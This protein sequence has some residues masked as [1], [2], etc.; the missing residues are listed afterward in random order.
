LPD[1]TKIDG[2]D[3][4]RRALTE[5]PD[6]F[7]QTFTEKLLT[8]ALG[9]TLEYDDMPA[10]RAI[11]RQSS[12]DGYRFSSIVKHTIASEPFLMREAPAQSESVAAAEDQ[13]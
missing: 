4:L 9:R 6:Q 2:T 12:H 8:F 1:G 13:R 10:V 11:V 5:R 3:D 7:V